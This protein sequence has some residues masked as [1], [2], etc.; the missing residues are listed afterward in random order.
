MNFFLRCKVR[1]IIV[2]GT[3]IGIGLLVLGG[4]AVKSGKITSSIEHTVRVQTHVNNYFHK[5]VI[6]ELGLCWNQL[7]GKGTVD[8]LHTYL[9]DGKGHWIPSLI[10]AE[11]STLP[12]GQDR[13]A[14][15]CMQKAVQGTMFSVME[16]Q[17]GD[18][19]F[20]LH[21]RWP[22]PT[23]KERPEKKVM[24]LGPGGG[25]GRGCDGEGAPAECRTCKYDSVTEMFDCI[26]V[27]VGNYEECEF[28]TNQANLP[29]CAT[30][31]DG[32]ASGG[33][34]GLV[35]GSVFGW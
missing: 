13:A 18:E 3:I 27:C 28:F 25:G 24:H 16:W 4:C 17:K 2:Q 34:F 22:V 33:P 29:G 26:Y 1:A 19:R 32:C 31:S 12:N 8:L 10:E 20:M 23:P 35:G 21:W 9:N 15:S 30:S 11:G 7:E 14:V 6:P 5:Q